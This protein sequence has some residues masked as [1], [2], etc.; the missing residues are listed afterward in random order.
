MYPILISA[1]STIAS[2]VIDS[3]LNSKAPKAAA[4]AENFAALLEKNAALP[5]TAAASTDAK[6]T[7]LRERLLDSPEVRTLLASA[8]PAKQP[9]LTVGADGTVTA[10]TSDGRTTIVTLSP[11]SA[12]AARELAALTKSASPQAGAAGQVLLPTSVLKNSA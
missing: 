11:E 8:D 5:S 10:R 4:P 6:I 1:A 7:A 9:T 12:A 3:W 2:N